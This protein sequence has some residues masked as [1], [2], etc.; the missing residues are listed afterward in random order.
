MAKAGV[1]KEKAKQL[2]L[3]ANGF[4]RQATEKTRTKFL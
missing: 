4:V 1:T 2:L 3:K